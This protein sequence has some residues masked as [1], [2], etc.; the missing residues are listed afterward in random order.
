MA[1]GDNEHGDNIPVLVGVDGSQTA[2]GAVRWAAELCT[3]TRSPMH[4][5][6]G[7]TH[8]RWYAAHEGALLLGDQSVHERLRVVGEKAL[9]EAQE[10][11][12]DAAP[13]V[14]V[15][16]SLLDGSIVEHLENLSARARMVVIGAGHGGRVRELVLGSHV[17]PIVHAA[18]CP[19]LAWREPAAQRTEVGRIVIGYDG[20]AGSEDALLAALDHAQ[21]TGARLTVA[22][23]WP[24]SALVGVGYATTLVDWDT[25][26]SDGERWL[27][28][29]CAAACEKYPDVAVD[30]AY[31]DSSPGRGL[32]NLSASAGLVVVGSRGR[33]EATSTLLGSVG[34]NLVHHARCPVLVVQ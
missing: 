28:R 33:G 17:M 9:T 14:D 29:R 4:L 15:V 12:H 25:I 8:S 23:F 27:A 20:S 26:R 6:H 18:Q 30:Y 24:V 16:T 1:H 3:R 5:I 13:G 11:V 32:V 34:E 19:V 2:L 7:V 31:E 10:V 22:S 21:S